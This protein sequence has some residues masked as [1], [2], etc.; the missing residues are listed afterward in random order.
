MVV[1][2]PSEFV[3]AALGQ[4]IALDPRHHAFPSQ[5]QGKHPLQPIPSYFGNSF[6]VRLPPRRARIPSCRTLAMRRLTTSFLDS[7][8]GHGADGRPLFMPFGL[9]GG[10]YAIPDMGT[11][12]RLRRGLAR[13]LPLALL[14]IFCLF[15]LLLP[16]LRN[17]YAL[18]LLGAMA[19]SFALFS[20]TF[21]LWVRH[22]TR[23]LHRVDRAR[24]GMP[25]LLDPDEALVRRLL[26]RVRPPRTRS[27]EE[28]LGA[29]AGFACQML[30]RHR[31][32]QE[33]TGRVPRGGVGRFP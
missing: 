11:A 13:L 5:T 33:G 19:A 12:Q 31:A 16:P 24:H 23:G 6:P 7:A 15:A 25:A 14:P 2:R 27:A 9:I 10:Q 32:E 20:L 26:D 29:L 8:F 1:F 4:R 28:T 30:L 18:P 17:A 22:A 21:F 3:N